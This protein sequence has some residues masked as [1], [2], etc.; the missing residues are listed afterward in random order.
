VVRGGWGLFW[1]PQFTVLYNG[2]VNAAPFSPQVTRYGVSFEDPYAGAQNPFPAGF[3]PFVPPADSDFITPLG[4]FGSFARNFQPSYQQMFNLTL[5]REVAPNWIVR[6]SYVGNLGRHLSVSDDINYARYAPGATTANIQQRR[7]YQNFTRIFIT[8]AETTSSYHGLQ[9]SVERRVTE[10]ISFEL[11]YTVSKSIDECSS[12]QTPQNPSQSV[13][14]NRTLNRGLSDFDL[15]QRLVASY[16]WALPKLSGQPGWVRQFLGSW[17]FTGITTIQSGFPFSVRSGVDRAMSGN[18]MDFAD[19]IGNPYLDPNRPR[20]ELIARYFDTAAFTL[21][22]LGTFGTAPRNLMRGPGAV[23]FDL[24][25]FKWFPLREKWQLQFRAELFN[26]F[27]KP[28]FGNP[29]AT[30][31]VANRFGRIENAGDPR[32]VQFALK[33]TF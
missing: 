17:Q 27:N 29:Y 12:D 28:N 25:L 2:F 20:A 6:A 4:S 24:G 22:A 7:P 23:N 30:A 15:P 18:N 16:V 21:N 13:P 14:L 9:L 11:N 33:L 8:S 1:N 26:A 3:A 31:N 5:E 19:L 32:I 10:G